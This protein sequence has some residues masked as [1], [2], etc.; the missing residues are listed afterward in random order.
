L[1]GHHPLE[2]NA[3]ALDNSQEDSAHDGTVSGSLVTTT[4]SQRSTSEKTGNDWDT[5]S[6]RS[7]T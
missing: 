2:S 4:D 5:I 3:D 6:S 7:L 1:V